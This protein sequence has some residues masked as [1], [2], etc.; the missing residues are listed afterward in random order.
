M[1]VYFS[2]KFPN[3]I[4]ECQNDIFEL[5]PQGFKR[6]VQVLIPEGTQDRID[7]R[8]YDGTIALRSS[9]VSLDEWSAAF[10]LG[11]ESSILGAL[12]AIIE[13]LKAQ[14]NY[15]LDDMLN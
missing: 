6:H 2:L 13:R 9:Q 10:D 12:E 11:L 8:E 14:E 3:A 1:G 15:S 7:K 5:S 4:E